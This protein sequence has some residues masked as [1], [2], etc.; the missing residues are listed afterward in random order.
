MNDEVRA[1][2]EG[3]AKSRAYGAEKDWDGDEYANANTAAAW[4]AWRYLAR[5][6]A[7]LHD[8]LK[9]IEEFETHDDAGEMRQIAADALDAYPFRLARS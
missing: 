2:F 3:W 9:K 4:E 1:Q 6:G 7:Q 8:A 5:M